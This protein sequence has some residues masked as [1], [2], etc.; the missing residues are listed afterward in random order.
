MEHVDNLHLKDDLF[1]EEVREQMRT[2][3]KE[4]S[5]MDIGIVG[6]GVVGKATARCFMEHANV[7]VYDV[8]PEKRT[9]DLADVMECSLVFVCLPTPKGRNGECDLSYVDNFFNMVGGHPTLF[10]LRSTVPVGA[11]ATLSGKYGVDVCHSPEFLTAR[12]AITDAQLPARNIIGYVGR[13]ELCE[14]AKLLFELYSRRFPGVSTLV[15]SSCESE[16]VKLTLNSFFAT[17]VAF[18]NEVNAYART[19]GLDWDKV[20]EGI[21]S[22]GRVAHSHTKV[23]GPDG[24]YGFGGACLPKDLSN[25]IHCLEECGLAAPVMR[26]AQL[27][28]DLLDRERH[29]KGIRERELW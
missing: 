15:M 10:V 17:K 12:C 14:S 22:D 25:L 2:R 26:G 7:K 18:F 9:H 27:R 23:P 6:G 3:S 20:M 8:I 1:P 28:N 13:Y 16:L 5:T 19:R 4:R 24:H 21:L 29:I 11:T